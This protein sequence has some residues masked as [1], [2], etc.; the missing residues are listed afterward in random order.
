MEGGD[1]GAG[2]EGG[3]VDDGP[4]LVEGEKEISHIP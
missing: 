1:V 2:G 3:E 4:F